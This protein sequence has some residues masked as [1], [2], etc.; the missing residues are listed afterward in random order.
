MREMTERSG[1]PKTGDMMSVI[2]FVCQ[3]P[4][5]DRDRIYIGPVKEKAGL[6]NFCLFP[7]AV[8][9]LPEQME[10]LRAAEAVAKLAAPD[11]ARKE[12]DLNSLF[13]GGRTK[14]R[15]HTPDASSPATSGGAG[16]A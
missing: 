8:T 5:A 2:R 3:T 13:V 12:T 10:I 7:Q 15:S 14:D 6:F 4:T 9:T 1:F 11:P 16:G